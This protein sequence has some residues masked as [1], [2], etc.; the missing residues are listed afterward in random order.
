MYHFLSLS[1]GCCG[2]CGGRL[3]SMG[4]IMSRFHHFL[5]LS[6]GCCGLCGGNVHGKDYKSF[7]SFLSLSVGCCSC[8]LYT[9]DA[10]DE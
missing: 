6:V 9:A 5:L 2:L 3:M 1:V 8:L 4:R 7:S 10:A